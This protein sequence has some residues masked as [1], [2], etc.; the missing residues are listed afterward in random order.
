M[1]RKKETTQLVHDL[2][3][4]HEICSE[5]EKKL[6]MEKYKVIPQELPKIKISDPAIRHLNPKVGDIIKIKRKDP[7]AG[8]SIYYRVVIHE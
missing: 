4:I 5:E 1:P 8:I 6:L 2:I 7:K 3:P